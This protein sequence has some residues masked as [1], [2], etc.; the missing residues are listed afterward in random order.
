M[1]KTC[2]YEKHSWHVEGRFSQNVTIAQLL[3]REV[4]EYIRNRKPNQ[5]R[6][7]AFSFWYKPDD[8]LSNG[9]KNKAY[10]EIVYMV[11]PLDPNVHDISL[12]IL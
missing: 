1:L 10:A 6:G 7:V 2:D 9:E 8:A 5:N 3:S 11:V 4:V 12:A